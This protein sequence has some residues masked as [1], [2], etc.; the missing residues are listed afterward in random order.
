[1][2]DP[3]DTDTIKEQATVMQR[4]LDATTV[5]NATWTNRDMGSILAHQLGAPL[6]KDLVRVLPDAESALTAMDDTPRTFGE[7]LQHRHPPVDI[8]RM[9]KDFAKQLHKMA[10][11]AYPE[12]VATLLYYAAIATAQ[13][14]TNTCITDLP[15]Q[16]LHKGYAWALT[17]TWLTPDLRTLFEEA[18]T[19][20][21][22]GRM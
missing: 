9:V 11:N 4:L 10:H 16:S 14:R 12:Q 18:Q 19:S 15:P 7:L 8:L 5:T 13:V 3:D 22:G 21:E 17:Q 6:I 2:K 20:I 1:V